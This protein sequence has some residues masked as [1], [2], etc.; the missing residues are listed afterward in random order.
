MDKRTFISFLLTYLLLFSLS[1]SVSE[2]TK[3]FNKRL[4]NGL[5]EPFEASTELFDTS[6]VKTIDVNDKEQVL[7]EI[8]KIKRSQSIFPLPLD[9]VSETKKKPEKLSLRKL[10]QNL[11][12]IKISTEAGI[13]DFTDQG[14]STKSSYQFLLNS[15]KPYS[16]NIIFYPYQFDYN[17]QTEKTETEEPQDKTIHYQTGA[18]IQMDPKELKSSSVKNIITNTTFE[19][20]ESR[21]IYDTDIACLKITVYYDDFL[22]DLFYESDSYY[23]LF[24]TYFGK[25]NTFLTGYETYKKE[26]E[27]NPSKALFVYLDHTDIGKKILIDENGLLRFK[28][29][30]IPDH[31][32][33]AETM[34]TSYFESSGAKAAIIDY[35]NKGGK[36]L[37]S[38]KSGVI[39]ENM[40]LMPSGTF[41][42]RLLLYSLHEKKRATFK[43]CD[44]TINATQADQPNYALQ[45][46]CNNFQNCKYTYSVTTY[47]MIKGK[48]S[49]FQVLISY[50]GKDDS[51]RMANADDGIPRNLTED[52]KGYLPLVLQKAY[53]K[54]EILLLNAN[55]AYDRE[56]NSILFNSVLYLL[57][58]P[59]L[60][61]GHVKLMAAGNKEIQIPAGEEG[62]ELDL[63]LQYL[64]LKAETFDSFELHIFLKKHVEYPNG[65]IP[66]GCVKS[67]DKIPQI[68]E[69]TMNELDASTHIVCSYSDP[70]ELMISEVKM[71]IRILDY[72][73]TQSKYNVLL[74]YPVIKYTRNG[75]NYF[76]DLGGVRTDAV[77]A[78]KLRAAIN[79][80]PSSFY[81]LPG[82]GTYVDN[83]IKIENKEDSDALNVTYFGVIPLITP[84]TDG[85]DQGSITRTIQLYDKYY[86]A[87]KFN[88]RFG[89]DNEYDY[90][91]TKYLNDKDVIIVNDWDT[92]VKPNKELRQGEQFLN[93]TN[94]NTQINVKRINTG[95]I[96][97][98]STNDVIKQI[99]FKNSSQFYMLASQRETAFAD[100]ATALGATTIYAN[101]GIPEDWKNPNKPG[102]ARKEFVF[103]RNDI[104]FYENDN[105]MLPDGMNYTHILTLDKYKKYSGECDTQFGFAKANISVAGY[106]NTEQ[107]LKPNEYTNALTH[108]FCI[109]TYIDPTNEEELRKYFPGDSVKYVH[110][111]VPIKEEDVTKPTDLYGFVADP[112]DSDFGY[113]KDYPTVKFIY[114]FSKTIKIPADITR[115]GGKIEIVLKSSTSLSLNV[116]SITFSPDQIAFIRTEYDPTT[117][118]ISAYFKRGLLSNEAYGKDSVIDINIE[119]LK[120]S[121][122]ELLSDIRIYELKFDISKPET[123]YESYYSRR[124]DTDEA[125]TRRAFISLPA[126]ELKTKLRRKENETD[127]EE[128]EDTSMRGYEMMEPFTR[129]GVYIQELVGHRTLYGTAEAHHVKDPGLQGIGEGFSTISNLGISSIPFVEYVTTGSGLLIPA[130]QFTSRVEWVDVWGRTW[131]QPLRTVFPDVPPIPP[132]LKNFMMSTTFEVLKKDENGNTQR[133]FSW[134]SDEPELQIHTTAKLLNNYPKYFEI[135][136]CK[137]NEVDYI[138]RKLGEGHSRIFDDPSEYQ[139]TDK[140]VPSTDGSYFLGTGGLAKYGSCF[141]DL[142]ATVGGQKL[143]Q[144]D[145][146]D[147][148]KV[149]VC[150][151]STDPEQI[152]KCEEEFAD[153]PTVK[154]RKGNGTETWNYSPRVENYYPKNYIKEDMWDLTHV[155]YDDNAMDKAYKYHM[156][157]NLPNLDLGGQQKPSNTI[158]FPIYKGC[159]YDISY[160]KTTPY[161]RN[162]TYKGWW[163]DNLQNKDDTCVAG[164]PTAND[165]SVDKKSEIEWIKTRDLKGK[166][167]TQVN[168]IVESSLRNIY[169]CKYNQYRAKT[170]INNQRHY[171][172]HNVIQNN[173]VPIIPDLE[174]DDPRLNHYN[175][176][177][178]QYSPENI[179]EVN[180]VVET[181]TD[182]DYLY[183]AAN[184]RGGAKETIHVVSTLKPI[185]ELNYEGSVKVNE[186]GRFVY[187]NPANGPNS[188]LIVDNPVNVIHAKTTKIEVDAVL[189]PTITTSYNSTIY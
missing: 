53:G 58:Q 105:Y 61:R 59:V 148:E 98:N 6:S 47:P 24:G 120:I 23:E 171:Q 64:K 121:E 40:G 111:L 124:N 32:M 14:G 162:P 1:L 18:M 96:T 117:K 146:E 131:S 106:Y 8:E 31:L 102:Q 153:I 139:V 143:T 89:E 116:D 9:R 28:Y 179:S 176:T 27:K 55:P 36:L 42:K 163:S 151:D 166:N 122:A 168:E 92:P 138:P 167:Q 100:T 88:L 119:D 20:E 144:K 57:G 87:Y 5:G 160:N 19:I 63:S 45:T 172:L 68:S 187:W 107:G 110:Y 76:I 74:A 79:P 99:S 189:Y 7:E 127:T 125:F 185:E 67:S 177:E 156:D 108:Y 123:N 44:S 165:V 150:A 136:R 134:P 113:M 93:T 75:V 145:V 48:D 60:L 34:I 141:A 52:E 184:L 178:E 86:K 84:V 16:S 49:S 137:N 56:Y 161:W 2:T 15:I 85:S 41:N 182:K 4:L 175:C 154:R 164:Q 132:P 103:A 12:G 158:M 65:N 188:Y 21:A 142:G 69:D 114:A 73:V 130:A 118:T 77:T 183:F 38:G 11:N 129:Y 17:Y 155:D 149:S 173:I 159:G 126:V 78:A 13:F 3:R 157:N 80:D 39:L 101:D 72:T 97:I 181:L 95:G 186:G 54:G 22:K 94:N 30:I 170:W 90:V 135:T 43:G 51:L 140:D 115:A 180:N 25:F 133:L 37:V 169:A 82:E 174:K 147:I 62:L 91:D 81:P 35:V 10:H 104:Y 83:V 71:K 33:G 128:I 112:N 46:I 29:L 109:R 66:S 152:L 50:N 70:A 26:K